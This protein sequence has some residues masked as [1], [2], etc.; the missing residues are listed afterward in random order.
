[1]TG[2][3]NCNE[4]KNFVEIRTE[5]AGGRGALRL[6]GTAVEAVAVQWAGQCGFAKWPGA[7]AG[8]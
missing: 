5:G 3:D 2:A 6:H 4:A 7:E 8:I 1:M